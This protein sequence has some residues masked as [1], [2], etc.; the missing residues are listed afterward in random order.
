MKQFLAFLLLLLFITG[1]T[2]SYFV[3]DFWAITVSEAKKF[4]EESAFLQN[5]IDTLEGLKEKHPV[6]TKKL[7]LLSMQLAMHNLDPDVSVKTSFVRLG[8][9]ATLNIIIS[10]NRKKELG[11]MIF[12]HLSRIELKSCPKEFQKQF[13]VYANEFHDPMSTLKTPLR[14]KLE[15]FMNV[16]EKQT[17]PK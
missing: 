16:F 1:L 7:Q 13:K 9:F 10:N 15:K 2:A 5:K 3:Y 4:D 8:F 17:S 14:E 6:T 11:E 12:D